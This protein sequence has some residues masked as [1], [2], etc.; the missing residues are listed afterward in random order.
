MFELK[1]IAQLVANTWGVTTR[2]Q[3]HHRPP[4]TRIWIRSYGTEVRCWVRYRPSPA[5]IDEVPFAVLILRPVSFH[6][7]TRNTYLCVAHLIR[8]SPAEI[9]DQR[10]TPS[11]W[12][13][14]P[15][16]SLA[17]THNSPPIPCVQLCMSDNEQDQRELLGHG[18]ELCVVSSWIQMQSMV[19]IGQ[20]LVQN[21][22][23]TPK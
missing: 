9:Q 14:P 7:N 4:V 1:P 22:L 13:R 20:C 11:P 5:V 8:R 17:L 6:R 3:N 23:C 15:P 2:P 18:M 12:A 16:P 21:N 10:W 19:V